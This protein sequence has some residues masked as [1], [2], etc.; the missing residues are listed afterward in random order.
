MQ[1]RWCLD[2]KIHL[3][4]LSNAPIPDE[5]RL[6]GQDLQ[7]FDELRTWNGIGS[8]THQV[9]SFLLAVDELE[10]MLL[11]ELV[12]M[13][14]RHFRGIGHGVEHRLAE[15][16]LSNADPIQPADQFTVQVGLEGMGESQ[17]VQVTI[18]FFD[19]IGNPSAVLVGTRRG[20]TMLQHITEV[21][22]NAALEFS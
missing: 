10:T 8:Q 9:I 2:V 15:K 12:Q 19:F 20:G 22:I 11:Q 17:L 3:L 1:L 21:R 5:G 7:L 18:G 13:P 14:K 4:P 16:H 6:D